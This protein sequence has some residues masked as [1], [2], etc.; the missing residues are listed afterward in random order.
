MANDA[1]G[2]GAWVAEVIVVPKPGVND[3]QGE[4][5]RGG[6]GSLGYS[7]VQRVRSGR[8]FRVELTAINEAAAHTDATAMCERLLS[9]PV[10][11]TYSFSL[12]PGGGQRAETGEES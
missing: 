2:H 12:F 9:N 3:P 1:S 7:G 11:E 5:I 4:A 10:I 6:L 8:F